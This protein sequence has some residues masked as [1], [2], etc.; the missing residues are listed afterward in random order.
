MAFTTPAG[1][2]PAT[3]N[4][5][6]NDAIDSDP[7]NGV[8]T[9]VVVTAGVAN[10]SV[11]AGF[12]QK[13][14]LGNIVWYDQNNDGIKQTT[15]T[16]VAGATV[17]LYADANNDNIADGAAVATTTT[18]ANGSYA[19]A[20]LNPGNYIVGVIIPAGYA[21]VTTNGGDPDNN[22]DNDNRNQ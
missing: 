17:N 4:V 10:T 22:I 2:T 12:N 19:F 20:N 18:A 11:D 9:G 21:V 1:Y 16:G 5:G 3:A 8:V 15:E 6:A 7:I 14:N 13:V